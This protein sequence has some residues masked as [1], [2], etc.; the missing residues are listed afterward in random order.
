MLKRALILSMIASPVALASNPFT[1]NS[2]TQQAIEKRNTDKLQESLEKEKQALRAKIGECKALSGD[3][4][5]CATLRKDVQRDGM[6]FMQAKKSLSNEVTSN[7]LIQCKTESTYVDN[8]GNQH[9]C[10][11]IISHLVKAGVKDDTKL[12]AAV[13]SCDSQSTYK[14]DKGVNQKCPVIPFLDTISWV[15]GAI[16]NDQDAFYQASFSPVGDS[17][18]YEVGLYKGLWY[19]WGETV[20]IPFY[21]SYAEPSSDTNNNE[22]SETLMDKDAG[23]QLSIPALFAFNSG[24]GENNKKQSTVMAGGIFRAVAKKIKGDTESEFVYGYNASIVGQYNSYLELFD[25]NDNGKVQPGSLNIAANYTYHNYDDENIKKI[26]SN[27][28]LNNPSEF[29]D[30]FESYGF[31]VTAEIGEVISIS[32]QW[33]MVKDDSIFDNRKIQRLTL[34]KSFGLSK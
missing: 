5:E 9:D 1:S 25:V 11:L 31:T 34:S 13:A 30:N 4:E 33:E 22:A 7:V 16:E 29:S 21:F 10:P 19:A 2:F 18:N 12:L 17:T 15:S 32:Y 23:I 26:A 20:K 28:T 14:D 3:T 6:A 24:L 27:L 8:N